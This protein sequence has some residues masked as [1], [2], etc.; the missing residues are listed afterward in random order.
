MIRFIDL[1]DAFWTEPTCGTPICAFLSTVT[2][3]FFTHG[4]GQHTFSCLD[5]FD[6]MPE[7]DRLLGLL[8]EGFFSS[9]DRDDQPLTR[10]ELLR[11]CNAAAVDVENWADCNTPQ[12]QIQLGKCM[13]L[14][15]DG[16]DFDTRVAHETI[17]VTI[18][19]PGFGDIEAGSG[20][21]SGCE[22]F[23]LPTR[24]QLSKVPDWY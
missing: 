15:M 13:I 21:C 2:G 24:E 7:K 10:Q 8:P 23:Y 16:C 20:R 5:D 12:A 18:W 1:S 6:D 11:I 9:E 22:E 14:L 4:D 17:W 3:K 19:W